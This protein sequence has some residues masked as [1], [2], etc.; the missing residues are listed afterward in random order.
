MNRLEFIEDLL[1]LMAHK[2]RLDALFWNII[3]GNLDFFILCNDAFFWACADVE[4]ITPESLGLLKQAF[5]DAGEEDGPLLYCAR[6]RK[7]RPQGA[8]YKYINQ[9]NWTLFH[10][11]GPER[12][13]KPGNTPLPD[14][15]DEFVKSNE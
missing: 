6:Q 1:T 13:V 14:G 4:E 8:M 7:M 10:A 15:V 12:E 11:C 9:K 5:E 2:D 3:R